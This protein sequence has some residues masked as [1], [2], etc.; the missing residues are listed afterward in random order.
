MTAVLTA[1]CHRH[2]HPTPLSLPPPKLGWPGIKFLEVVLTQFPEQERL[3]IYVPE[4]GRKTHPCVFIAPAGSNL[5]TGMRLASDDQ[6]EHLPY[7]R[8]GYEVVAYDISGA[9]PADKSAERTAA[10]IRLFAKRQVGV[11][12]GQA[13]I[14]Y[15][16]KNLHVDPLRLYA[17][18]HSSAGTLALELASTDMRVRGCIAY[19]PVTDVPAFLAGTLGDEVRFDAPEAL[20]PLQRY[21]PSAR[22][23]GLKCPVMLF[24]SA[25]DDTVSPDSVKEYA[26][27]LRKTNR[28]VDLVTA[29]SGGHYNAMISKGIPA[30]IEWL[31]RDRR[32]RK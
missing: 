20:G 1:G 14:D 24:T 9:T 8:A 11:A 29:P 30:G 4:D 27:E 10:A 25:D 21:S 5:V 2:A 7:V 26:A 17:A 23:E 15:A 3:W 13:A 31:G 16:I 12:N 6:A 18:G 28:N 19:A 22:L 32:A